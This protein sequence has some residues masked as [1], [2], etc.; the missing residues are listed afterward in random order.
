MITLGAAGLAAATDA[1]LAAGL[2]V[3]AGRDVARGAA[4]AVVTEADWTRVAATAAAVARVGVGVGVRVAAGVSVAAAEVTA[5][6]V[7]TG[8]AA[9]GDGATDAA[10][11]TGRGGA[12]G[13]GADPGEA[14][15]ATVEVTAMPML[16]TAKAAVRWRRRVLVTHQVSARCPGD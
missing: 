1:G 6:G 4:A 13:V 11:T 15:A 9:L 2:V 5:R 8:L 7:E 12:A 16:T 14:S 3:V 10:A